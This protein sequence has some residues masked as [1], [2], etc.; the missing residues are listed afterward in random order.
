MKLTREKSPVAPESKPGTKAPFKRIT[1]DSSTL[2][3]I[4]LY[5]P[6][7]QILVI[8]FKGGAQ[9]RY[10]KIPKEVFDAFMESPSKGKF[11][12]ANIKGKFEFVKIKHADP[13]PEKG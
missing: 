4:E 2:D 1:L 7:T 12:H 10:E 11:Y 8:G 9:Y 6:G 13:K 5:E 3:A